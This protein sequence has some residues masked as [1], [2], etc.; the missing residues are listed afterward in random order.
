MALE[1]GEANVVVND[2]RMRFAT[3]NWLLVLVRPHS[4]MIMVTAFTIRD[5][6]SDSSTNTLINSN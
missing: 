2:K 1:R 5:T 4:I 6:I 3:T